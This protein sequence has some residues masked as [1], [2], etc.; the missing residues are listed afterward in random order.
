MTKK[1]AD[2]EIKRYIREGLIRDL[3]N[4]KETKK[5]MKLIATTLLAAGAAA[6]HLED[7]T[8]CPTYNV[9]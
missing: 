3:T 8:G 1:S 5:Q 7:T 9:T 6:I 2:A 4:K